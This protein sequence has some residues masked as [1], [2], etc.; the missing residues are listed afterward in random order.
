MERI[1]VEKR[2]RVIAQR[3][4]QLLNKKISKEAIDAI[5]SDIIKHEE[6]LIRDMKKDGSIIIKSKSYNIYK[7]EE[8]LVE[9]ASLYAERNNRDMI[10]S[11]DVKSAMKE[12][13]PRYW[14]FC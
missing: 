3:R 10:L 4:A 5:N 14:P 9:I 6:P 8:K 1:E 11:I 12:I 13:C 7:S 2:I